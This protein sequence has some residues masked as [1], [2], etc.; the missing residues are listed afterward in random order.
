MTHKHPTDWAFQEPKA[1][2]HALGDVDI[3]IHRWMPNVPPKEQL[4]LFEPIMQQAI[5]E[6]RPGLCSKCRRV[7]KIYQY[8]RVI[9][10]TCT[11]S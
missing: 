10:A 9:N 5:A 3:I 4:A 11:T 8:Y 2:T 6:A 7:R 1:L